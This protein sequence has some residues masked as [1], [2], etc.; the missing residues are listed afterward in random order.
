MELGGRNTYE[1]TKGKKYTKTTIVEIGLHDPQLREIN[2]KQSRKTP[3]SEHEY[4]KK[5]SGIE[6][7]T[8]VE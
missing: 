7:S 1:P 6:A 4:F 5:L 2:S 8:Y 3:H